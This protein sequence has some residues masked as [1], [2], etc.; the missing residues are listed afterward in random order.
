MAKNGAE[1]APTGASSADLAQLYDCT[2]RQIE[3]LAAKG[4]VVRIGR[5]RYNAAASTRNYVRH[6]REQAAS[7]AGQDPNFDPA[8]ANVKWK[9]TNTRLVQLRLERE[10]G[11]LVAIED[12]RD[13][14][15]RIVRG[16]RQFVL[17]LPGKIAFEVPTLTAHD[18][19]VVE[20]IC[21]DGLEDAALGRGFDVTS[22]VSDLEVDGGNSRTA[23]PA[24]E[25]LPL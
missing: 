8:A 22:D 14:W 11:N 20:R 5:G 24:A 7:R 4:I 23:S 21:H 1:S 19:G 17:A 15:G 16:I 13:A 10:A 18:R 25:A 6:L 2:V 3:L 12:V 9:E